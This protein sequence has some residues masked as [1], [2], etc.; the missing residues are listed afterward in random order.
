M[1]ALKKL[2]PSLLRKVRSTKGAIGVVEFAGVVGAGALIIGGAIVYLIG[3]NEKQMASNIVQANNTLADSMVQYL[4]HDSVVSAS[5]L[6]AALPN[7]LRPRSIIVNS[8]GAW[9]G[10]HGGPVIPTG[11]GGRGFVLTWEEMTP[12]MCRQTLASWG[13]ETGA[14]RLTAITVNLTAQT[15]P[16]NSTTRNTAC[17]EAGRANVVALTYST[18]RG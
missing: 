7:N 5:N 6:T 3:E 16:L 14:G 11:T 13:T 17:D 1:K 4:R 9:Q 12:D 8:S 2:C 18:E 10:P 15:L